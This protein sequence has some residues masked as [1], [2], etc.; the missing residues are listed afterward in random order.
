M[1]FRCQLKLA[2]PSHKNLWAED[3]VQEGKRDYEERS[4]EWSAI[5][6]LLV[7]APTLLRALKEIASL[8]LGSFA[9]TAMHRAAIVRNAMD[10]LADNTPLR[11]AQ[12][13]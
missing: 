9:P 1:R 2:V 13:G 8:C 10:G 4:A 12:C 5:R 11:E 3:A 7:S 6:P